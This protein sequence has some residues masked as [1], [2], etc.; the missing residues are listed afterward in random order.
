MT[1]TGT[2]AFAA[3]RAFDVF[4]HDLHFADHAVW[5]FNQGFG[6]VVAPLISLIAFI[7]RGEILAESGNNLIALFRIVDDECGSSDICNTT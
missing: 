4:L 2:F 6:V 3:L 1:V 7:D 5:K